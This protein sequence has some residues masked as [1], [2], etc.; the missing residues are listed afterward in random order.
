MKILVIG[1][2]YF[3]GRVFTM[4]ASQKHELTLINRGQYSMKNLGV[5]ELHFDRHDITHLKNITEDYD[6][7]VDFCAYQEGDIQTIVES[8]SGKIKHYIFISTCDVYQRDA[9][10]MKDENYSFNT[11]DYGGETGNYINQKV[12]LEKELVK[13]CQKY[14]IAYSSIRP[15]NIYG[16]FNYAPRESLFIQMIV[17][18]SPFIRLKDNDGKFQL[19]YV[20]DVAN[21]I[22]K[23]IEEKAYN[24]SFN[25]VSN[26]I[27]DYNDLYRIL[28]KVSHSSVQYIEM[29]SQEAMQYQYPLPYPINKEE[30]QLYDGQKIVN[31]FHFQYTP[32]KEGMEKTY[33]AF[34]PVF[35]EK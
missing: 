10:I 5:K 7:V 20:K 18:Q 25:I 13:V 17:N 33:Q 2:T 8:I 30:T 3:L 11:I 9:N 26:E 31:T 24:E 21:A 27:I 14:D 15:A 16:P 35:K 22:I 12:L 23:V 6:A 29:S 1:G 4:F 34:L 28:E 32:L 19:V